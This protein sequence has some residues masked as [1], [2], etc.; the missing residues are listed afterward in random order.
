MKKFLLIFLFAV[1][2]S[3]AQNDRIYLI[4][5]KVKE[6]QVISI[7]S[8]NVFI[9]LED[10]TNRT[11][12]YRKDDILLIEKYDGKVIV[13][14]KK[15]AENDTSTRRTHVY[16]NSISAEP[17][18]IFLGR[19]TVCY[20]YLSKDGSIGIAFPESLTFDPV[21]SIYQQ[22]NDSTQNTSNIHQPGFNFI[23][24]LDLN[25]YVRL[26]DYKGLFAGPR[27]RYGVD[28]FLRN[29]EGYSLQTQVGMKLGDEKDHFFHQFSFGFGFVRVLSSPAGNRI[30]PKES[31]GWFSINYRLGLNF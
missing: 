9:K 3:E 23:G 1:L 5:G 25:F 7:G 20:E 6:G 12:N 14:G 11:L 16:R 22:T 2:Y 31:F 19:A 18:N 28:M 30:N 21:G 8:K 15:K 26:G 27:I 17:F 29:I 10:S 24:G 4:N 13:F